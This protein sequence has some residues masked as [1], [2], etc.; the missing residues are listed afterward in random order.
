MCFGRG[1]YFARDVS[2]SAHR[3]F[4]PPDDQGHK[5]IYMCKVVVGDCVVGKR[6]MITPPNQPGTQDSYDCTV[7]RV[8]NPKIFVI[9]HDAQAYPEYL[10]TFT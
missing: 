4:S 2:Y 6:D 5:Y 8:D 10:I 3:Q 1:S 9:Y 7:D